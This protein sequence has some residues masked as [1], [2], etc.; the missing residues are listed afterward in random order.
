MVIVFYI[1]YVQSIN[2]I[3]VLK[4]FSDSLNQVEHISFQSQNSK[5]LFLS[6]VLQILLKSQPFSG[7]VFSGLL[8]DGKQGPKGQPPP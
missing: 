6:L 1:Q 5:S 3:H 7:W 4:L 8:T 2:L